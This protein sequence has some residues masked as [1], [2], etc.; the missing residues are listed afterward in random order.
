MTAP[1]DI[2]YDFR[3]PY[4]Y[5]AWWRIRR[6]QALSSWKWRWK[7]VS[8]DVLL[9][10]QAGREPLAPYVDPLPPP[11]RK[12]FLADIRRSANF[13]G[14]PLSPPHQPRPDPAPALCVALRLAQDGIPHDRFID[15]V[16]EAMWQH[17]SD[18]GTREVLTNCLISAALG[19]AMIESAV[20]PGTEASW[21]RNPCRRTRWASSACRVLWRMARFSLEPTVWT[22]WHG[23][24]NSNPTHRIAKAQWNLVDSA[25]ARDPA[26]RSR[27]AAG[28][29]S[30]V[31]DARLVTAYRTP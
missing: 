6:Q 5:L 14:A 19:E 16:F 29:R 24:W 17:R 26:G 10:L 4:A 3:S 18:I 31:R 28:S 2:Y 30:M 11:K 12:H 15:M 13:L 9:N 8:I 27:R 20:S 23:D 1:I 21:S 7:P 22:C 25:Q